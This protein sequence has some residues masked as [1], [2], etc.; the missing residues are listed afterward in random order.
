MRVLVSATTIIENTR[1]TIE[2]PVELEGLG[3]SW[4]VHIFSRR[5][6][7]RMHPFQLYGRRIFVAGHRGMVG[8]ALLRR[9][10]FDNC[11][12]L[13]TDERRLDLTRQSGAPQPDA[14]SMAAARAGGILANSSFPADFLFP[15]SCDG[16]ERD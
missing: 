16:D 10:S 8:S 5:V 15:K 11:E 2:V 14:V 12:I 1:N 4:F 6:R 7:S 13:T 9:L 3:S